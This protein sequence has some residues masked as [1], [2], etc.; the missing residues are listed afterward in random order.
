M[1]GIFRNVLEIQEV[2]ND[3]RRKD[4]RDI[5]KFSYR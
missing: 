5:S 3:K 4:K 1:S 2:G